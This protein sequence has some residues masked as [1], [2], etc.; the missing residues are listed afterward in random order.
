M[1]A[2]RTSHPIIARRVEKKNMLQ[3]P[4]DRNVLLERKREI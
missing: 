2:R 3:D 1:K 4:P